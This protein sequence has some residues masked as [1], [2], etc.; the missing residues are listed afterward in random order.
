M[1]TRKRAMSRPV[2][3]LVGRCP[4]DDGITLE[5]A[6]REVDEAER[7]VRNALQYASECRRR[8]RRI[9]KANTK[10]TGGLPAKKD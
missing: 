5:D 6:G 9:L 10:L 2:D 8:Y 4:D 1:T 3:G 7:Q